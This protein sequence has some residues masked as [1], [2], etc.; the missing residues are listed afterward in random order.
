MFQPVY[1]ECIW[2]IFCYYAVY[3][4]FRIANSNVNRRVE[5]VINRQKNIYLEKIINYLRMGEMWVFSFIMY[6]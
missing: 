6:Y 3:L 5:T 2:F 4:S 1:R